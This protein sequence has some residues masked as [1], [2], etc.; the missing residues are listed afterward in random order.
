MTMNN[1]NPRNGMDTDT[2]EA[3]DVEQDIQQE[4]QRGRHPIR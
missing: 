1:M 4:D 3:G 2:K